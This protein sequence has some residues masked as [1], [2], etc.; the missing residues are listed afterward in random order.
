MRPMRALLVVVTVLFLG[1]TL[2]GYASLPAR[3]PVHFGI[4]G[5][6]DRWVATSA[7][8]WFGPSALLL[9]LGW[10]TSL[11]GPWLMRPATLA[12]PL[13][14]FPGKATYLGLPADLQARLRPALL[15][16][17]DLVSLSTVL[18]AA[19]LQLMIWEGATRPGDS[20]IPWAVL[21]GPFGMVLVGAALLRLEDA[22][23]QAA[24][25]ARR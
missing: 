12:S 17:V 15:D 14:S 4:D 20:P 23:T 11:A 1:A 10:A 9:G 18:V 25:T 24:R 3:L 7:G 6:P 22:I 19:L 8:W 21:G 5:T 13:I 2:W 16:F